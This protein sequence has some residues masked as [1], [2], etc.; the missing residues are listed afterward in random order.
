MRR[1]F[2]LLL[3]LGLLSP[4]AGCHHVAGFCDCEGGGGCGAGTPTVGTPMPWYSAA[5]AAYET[6][7]VAYEKASPAPVDVAD[8]R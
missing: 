7:P 3:A 6:V 4:L 2:V 1:L 8:A 5:P